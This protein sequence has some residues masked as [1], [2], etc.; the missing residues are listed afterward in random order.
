MLS[1]HSLGSGLRLLRGSWHNLP[2]LNGRCHTCMY[3][4]QRHAGL[5][6][7]LC[8]TVLRLVVMQ[9]FTLD[10]VPTWVWNSPIRKSRDH[11]FSP[12]W[13]CS[14]F[15]KLGPSTRTLVHK[16]AL[17]AN[18]DWDY[19]ARI[20]SKIAIIGLPDGMR[21]G[22]CS[23]SSVSKQYPIFLILNYVLKNL[24]NDRQLNIS[25]D[26]IL[27]YLFTINRE[28]ETLS[29]LEINSQTNDLNIRYMLMLF[30]YILIIYI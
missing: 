25:N 4:V 19:M 6:M 15:E 18:C 13:D 22:S 7:M 14:K 2:K 9:L 23:E 29:K 12:M 11:H 5:L 28:T 21:I 30:I 17:M 16:R 26:K 20:Q 8:F 27:D 10:I 1:S 3:L 24:T